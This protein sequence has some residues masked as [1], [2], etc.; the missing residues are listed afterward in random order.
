[1]P[2]DW[3]TA[4][5]GVTRIGSRPIFMSSGDPA[6]FV[7][8]SSDIGLTVLP[9][10]SYFFCVVPSC[11]IVTRS[12]KHGLRARPAP[13][14]AAHLFEDR[15]AVLEL[16]AVRVHVGGD[17]NIFVVGPTHV[18][19]EFAGGGPAKK[20]RVIAGCVSNLF[21]LVEMRPF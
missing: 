7:V 20:N 21:W 12:Y 17:A 1:M 8:P 11:Q 14:R 9:R 16:A 15:L 6:W 19:R 2:A 3:P 13:H 4:P 18:D 5:A 10:F